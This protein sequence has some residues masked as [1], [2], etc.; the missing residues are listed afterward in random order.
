MLNKE[1]NSPK[2]SIITVVYNNRN[3][4]YKTIESVKHQNY[5]NIEYIVIDGGSTDG[6]LEEIKRNNDV[7]NKW[8]SEK[9]SG[10]YDAMNKGISI[11]TG[12]YIWFLNGGDM[13]YSPNTLN[14][15]FTSCKEADV[16]YGDTELVDD[17]GKS[18]GKRKLKTPPENLSWKNMIDGMVITHQSLII[19]KNIIIPYDLSFKHCSDI[20]WTIKILKSSNKIINTRI[21]IS[22]FLLGG[23]SRK[24]TI[25]SL[26]ERIRILSKHFNI[27]LVLFNHF[28]LT[29]RFL[30][31]IIRYRRIL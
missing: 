14:E 13:I 10:I 31:H 23:Y 24:N 9:D 29:F 19:K 15:V 18:Y 20:D 26:F 22:K 25:S 27:I 4:F 6:T 7:V 11:A 21:I 1:S 5:K 30:V 28:K 2:I 16:Y 12:D 3:N 17:D 8:I